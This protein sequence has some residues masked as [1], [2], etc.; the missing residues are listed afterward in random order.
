[1][2]RSLTIASATLPGT[3]VEARTALAKCDRVDECKSWADKA[4]A[5]A[6]Y[7]KQADDDQMLVMARRIQCR[8]I[9]RGGELLVQVKAAR[10]TGK[11]T[12]KS[13]RGGAPPNSRKA[14][15][16]DAGLSPDQAKT[17]LRVVNVPPAIRNAMIE[18][19]RPPTV[20][21]LADRGRRRTVKPK[22]YRDEWCDWVFG[23]RRLVTIPTCGLGVLAKYDPNER[24][25]FMEEARA[26]QC[27][28]VKW[29][30]E[31]EKEE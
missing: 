2:T 21:E 5:L 13:V 15:A 14:F 7:A 20:Q 10:G 11:Q 3:Y 16:K 18:S 30:N 1:V 19:A 12:D 22:P 8:A 23:V 6:S 26:A 4:A 25:K 28:I 27:N 24:E 9:E 31:L 29:I 17:M